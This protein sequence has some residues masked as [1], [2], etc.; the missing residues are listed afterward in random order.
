ML[1]TKQVAALLGVRPNTISR[2][3]WEE[4]L[5]PPAKGPGGA[6]HWGRS[7]IERASWVLRHRSADDILPITARDYEA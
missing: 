4:R 2:A 7:D 6:Y 3:I 1:G 5:A